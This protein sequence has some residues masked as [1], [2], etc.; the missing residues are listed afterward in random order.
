MKLANKILLAL[1]IKATVLLL[2]IFTYFTNIDEILG[3]KTW[4]CEQKIDLIFTNRC[5]IHKILN[6][7]NS[8]LDV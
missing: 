1:K 4:K 6:N 2:T 5:N 8:Q 7:D 3:K